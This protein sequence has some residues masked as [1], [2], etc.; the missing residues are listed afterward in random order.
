MLVH[1]L[2]PVVQVQERLSIEQIENEDDAV[3]PLV[4]RVGDSSIPLLTGCV[5]NLKLNLLPIVAQR[6][7]S[8]IY[9]NS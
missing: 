3:G 9:S 8:E 6:P 7:E 2:Q 5:P 4:I 1:F